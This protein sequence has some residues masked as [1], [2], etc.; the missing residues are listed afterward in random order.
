MFLVAGGVLIGN[1]HQI[2]SQFETQCPDD[3]LWLDLRFVDYPELMAYLSAIDVLVQPYLEASQSGNTPTALSYGVPVISTEVGGLAEPI[4]DGVNGLL[5]PPNDPVALAEAVTT[6]L[7]DDHLQTM[8]RHAQDSATQA[9]WS[10]IAK[11]T[12]QVYQQAARPRV[13]TGNSPRTTQDSSLARKASM[14]HQ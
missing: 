5:I 2:A 7:A 4:D 11:E 3:R 10:T 14:G 6:C 13:A 9:Q 8:A 1:R 12:L